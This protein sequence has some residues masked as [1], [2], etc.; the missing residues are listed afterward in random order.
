MET[1]EERTAREEVDSHSFQLTGARSRQHECQTAFFLD[2]GMNET[3]ELRDLLDFINDHGGSIGGCEFVL[4][5]PLGGCR[6]Q[7]EY[8]GIE[9]INVQS[10]TVLLT[11]Q[12]RFAG[13][14]RSEEEIALLWRLEKSPSE[15]HFGLHFGLACTILRDCPGFVKCFSDDF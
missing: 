10:I 4:T 9:Q 3:K 7:P 14:S 8:L 2:Q 5:K 1:T 6:V 11:D 12:C 15:F 13:A